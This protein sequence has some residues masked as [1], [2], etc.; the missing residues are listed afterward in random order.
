MKQLL[1]TFMAAIL[2]VACSGKKED[3]SAGQPLDD[4]DTEEQNDSL[5]TEALDTLQ[6]FEEK[7]IPKTADL[8]FDDFFYSFATDQNFQSQRVA[9]PLHG[10]EQG[11]P[12]TMTHEEWTRDTDFHLSFYSVLYERERDMEIQKDTSLNTVSVERVSLY[13]QTINRFH[14]QR[15]DGQWVVADYEK[16]STDQTP[17]SDFL[18]FYAKFMADSTFQRESIAEPLKLVS[19]WGGDGDEESEID[20]TVDDW[21]E[22]RK[23]MP[24][25]EGVM[26]N[27]NYGQPALSENRKI[28]LVQGMSNEMYVKYKF[29]RLDG[30]WRLIEIE[31]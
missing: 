30:K 23:E 15:V 8:L 17:N 12:S 3:S 28:L 9:F 14:F 21:F 26:T 11:E 13:D 7:V 5:E 31:N 27:V 19:A 2:I 22:F 29:D 20:L 6:L 1:A 24:M 18:H 25:P 16:L 10:T 4:F